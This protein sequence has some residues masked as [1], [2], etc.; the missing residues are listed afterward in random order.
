MR[1][2][3]PG[4]G[5][6]APNGEIGTLGIQVVVEHDLGTVLVDSIDV[7]ALALA[8]VEPFVGSDTVLVA[9]V[10]CGQVGEAPSG[11]GAKP[12]L[13]VHSQEQLAE[14][15]TLS[16]KLARLMSCESG[17]HDSG[18]RP[19]DSFVRLAESDE[20]AYVHVERRAF[21]LGYEK[22]GAMQFAA[23][24]YMHPEV[25]SL[26]RA[27]RRSA[28]RA[29]LEMACAREAAS[30]ASLVARPEA[31]VGWLSGDVAV[32]LAAPRAA[33]A[34]PLVSVLRSGTHR[35]A[36]A[37]ASLADE[38]LAIVEGST[39]ADASSLLAPSVDDLAV[40]VGAVGVT[41]SPTALSAGES[42]V[43]DAFS[44]IG[45]AASLV[46]GPTGLLTEVAE[47]S[48]LPGV[49]TV[50]IWPDRALP[51]SSGGGRHSVAASAS[52]S[53]ACLAGSSRIDER[54]SPC[55][56]D[57]SSCSALRVLVLFAGRRRPKSLRRAL[58]RLG[59]IVVTFEI[60]DD[61]TTIRWR[62]T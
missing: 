55:G 45:D 16:P 10:Q 24:G 11:A 19:V 13:D 2:Q 37:A 20:L 43:T 44:T 29:Q 52:D 30:Q 46:T 60:L 62:R 26:R 41:D 56:A 3:D 34:G 58:E 1:T 7:P 42:S 28:K 32:A 17:V 33:G 54:C 50:E 48:A 40:A 57:S 18:A 9:G 12:P 27:L 21:S 39:V 8:I 51:T 15:L 47:A 5:W 6:R 36:Q 14:R 25:S 35:R 53:V 61:P 22:G 4:G 38:A 23:G 59:V 49:G 31:C